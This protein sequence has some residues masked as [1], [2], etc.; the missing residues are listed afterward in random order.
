MS[1]PLA[2]SGRRVPNVCDVAGGVE[3]DDVARQVDRLV[4]SSSRRR[5]VSTW[6]GSNSESPIGV[7]LGGEERE[8]HRRRRSP[9]RRRCPSR[10]SMTPSLSLTP[11]PRRARRRTGGSGSSRRPSSTSTSRW[12]QPARRRRQRTAAGRRCE[13][14]A[15]CDGAEGV[16]DVAVDPLDEL[17]RRT[18]RRCPPRPGRS[19]GSRAAR[20]RAPARPGGPGRAPSST[21]GPACPSAARGGWRVTTVG[22]ALAAATR[23]SAGRRGC[24]SRR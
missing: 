19:A 14:W 21:S 3:A 22:A 10:A 24:G 8:A 17:L 2:P 16:V 5:Q 12:Q 9:A 4:A 13:A 6:S 18:R 11:W 20:R 23:S 1:R 7:A 15:R